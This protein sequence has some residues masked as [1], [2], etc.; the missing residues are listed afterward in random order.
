MKPNYA[1]TETVTTILPWCPPPVVSPLGSFCFGCRL[2]LLLP[3]D[4]YTETF[5]PRKACARFYTCTHFDMALVCLLHQTF[6]EVQASYLVSVS[7]F[8][9]TLSCSGHTTLSHLVATVS[10]V[11]DH[12]KKKEL[13]FAVAA[14]WINTNQHGFGILNFFFSKK[15]IHSKIKSFKNSQDFFLYSTRG[16]KEI[17]I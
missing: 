12:T 11:E 6:E 14:D 5:C 7:H 17:V 15:I 13:L 10:L 1:K 9:C 2:T 16:V 3:A 4:S 8:C